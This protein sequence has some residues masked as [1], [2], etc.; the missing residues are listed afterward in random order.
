MSNKH[1]RSVKGIMERYF[2]R[3]VELKKIEMETP[4]ETGERI[5]DDIFGSVKEM[6]EEDG[7]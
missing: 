6:L 1:F 5:V 7:R 4:K 3:K 2:P